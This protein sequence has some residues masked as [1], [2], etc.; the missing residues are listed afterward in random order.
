MKL[1]SL[2]A[3]AGIVLATWAG[4]WLS[5]AADPAPAGGLATPPAETPI[6]RSFAQPV[7]EVAVGKKLP[8]NRAFLG[9]PPPNPH[10]FTGDRDGAQC[11]SCHAREN[12]IE[13]RQQAI[14]PVPHA[15]FTQCQGCHV[16]G[17]ATAVAEFRANDFVGLDD[18]G[19]GT[20][21]HPLAPPTIPHKT[22]MRDNCL[23]CHGPAGK[24]RIATPHPA[25]SQCQQCHVSDATRNYDRPVPWA[26]LHG[27]L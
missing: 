19:K 24:Q 20:R 17:S 1:M 6:V 14:A 12:R 2:R 13:K 7:R 10:A 21:A 4:L 27:E 11:L 16:N 5:G 18:P 9:A 25:R 23:S 22:F 3:V 15:E 26:E 8:T